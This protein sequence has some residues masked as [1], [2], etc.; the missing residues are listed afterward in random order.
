[1]KGPSLFGYRIPAK[2]LV[3][4]LFLW[5]MVGIV[6]WSTRKMPFY[7]EGAPGPRFMPVILAA[8]LGVLNLLY[9]FESAA[10]EFPEKRTI[11][12]RNLLRPAGFFAITI[13]L[14]LCWESLGALSAVS[15][16]AILELKFLERYSWGKSI[17]ASLI[18][19]GATLVLFQIILGV[20]LPGGLFEMLSYVRL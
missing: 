17:L 6:L 12:K 14:V 15:L 1:M 7:A 20:P 5:L 9:W 8:L 10:K 19:G 16:C 13:L 11:E 18:I 3:G 4:G 2:Q